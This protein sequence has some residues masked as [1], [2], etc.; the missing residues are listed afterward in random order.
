MATTVDLR[1]GINLIIGSIPVSLDAS[2]TPVPNGTQYQFDGCVQTAEISL[3]NFLSFVAQQFNVNLQLPPE[4]NLE[5]KIDYIAG[6]VIYTKPTTGNPSTQLGAAAKFELTIEGEDHP[7]ILSFYAASNIQSPAPA[8]GNPY[9]V[10]AAIELDLDFSKLP[11][12]GVIPGFQD[13]TLTKIGFSYSNTAGST[14][15][16]NFAIPQVDTSANPLYTG[17]DPNSR[18]ANA[19]SISTTGN[20]GTFN[21]GAQGFSL[22]AG[23]MNKASGETLNNFALPMSLPAAP[24]TQTSQPAPYYPQTTSPPASPVH[25]ISINKTFGPVNLKQIGL[26]YSSGEASFGF[27][28][29]FTLAAFSLDLQGLTITFPMPL[30]GQPAGKTTSFDL[31][32]LSFDFDRGGLQIGGAFEKVMQNGFPAYYGEVIVQVASFG[33]KAMGGYAP[34]HNGTPASFFLYANIDIPLGGPPFLFVTGFAGGF[35][36]NNSLIL[37][38]IDT[39]PGYLLLPGNA[40]QEGSSAANTIQQVL[41][42]LVQIFQPEPGEYWVA[43]GIQ[44]TSFEMI[45]AFALVTVAFGVDLQIGVL[46]S[47]SMTLP[48]GDPYPVAYVEIDLVASFTPANGLLAVAGVLSPASFLYGGFV[49]LSGGF[50]FYTWFSGTNQGNFVVSLGGYNSAY[51]K[52]S[53][54][55]DVPRL[56]MNFGLGPLQVTGQAYF[57]LTPA[58]MMAGISMSA[59]WS[60]GPIKAWLDVGV[61]FLIAWAPFNYA[62]DAYLSIGCSAN[63]GLLTINVHVG[64]T[65]YVWGPPFGGK[66]TV[67]LDVISFTIKFGAAPAP[68]PPVGWSAFRTNFLPQ[69]SSSSTTRLPRMAL[70][71]APADPPPTTNIIKASVQSGLLQSNVDGFDWIVDPETFVIVT[72]STIPANNAQWALSAQQNATI[73]D[74]VSSYNP[75]APTANLPYLNLP[76]GTQTFSADLVWNPSLSIG[77]MN[78]NNVQSFHVIQLCKRGPSDPP[79]TFSDYLYS[80]TAQ[81]LLTPSSAA[82]WA[83][84]PA[85]KNANDA[86]FVNATLTGFQIS[87]IPQQPDEVSGV[88]LGDLLFEPGNTASFSY[89]SQ[90]VDSSYTVQSSIDAQQDLI[91]QISGAY[92]EN[93]TNSGYVLSALADPWVSSQRASLL[94]DLTANGFS[95]YTSSEIDVSV[96]ATETALTDWP[97]V[98]LLGA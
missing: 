4:L 96:L 3:G 7:L 8:S 73:P 75:Q 14:T 23:F 39:L 98:E 84:A 17:S 81:P 11:V 10:G 76:A 40:P 2:L 34:A 92:S 43:A 66:A 69:D 94:D 37:P 62:A 22:T 52:P 20:Q 80:V 28:A 97:V 16:V 71:T 63:L 72:N 31:Q 1:V 13:L 90:A 61:D 65:L 85:Q 9:V 57:A 74:A 70:A 67:D 59:T 77:P 54:Y 42:K 12:V 83:S 25:W 38:T 18:N 6:Q 26:N 46:G 24:S 30:P 93:I 47:C 45:N 41:P 50:A 19:Y 95:T 48:T 21:L 60:S 36:I 82:L 55:P 89:Q 68:P 88:P 91:I 5:A 58:M 78:Q 51:S 35:G 29:G 15:P 44:F 56:K 49:H 79:G 32:G 64:A 86:S 27:S 33:L 87:P 53:I